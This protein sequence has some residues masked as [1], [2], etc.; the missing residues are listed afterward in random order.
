MTGPLYSDDMDATRIDDAR[1][2]RFD[3]LQADAK[4]ALSYSANTIDAIVERYREAF[5]EAHARYQAVRDEVDALERR[6]RREPIGEDAG[7]ATGSRTPAAEAAEAAEAGADDARTRALRA[8]L[9]LL[10]SDV[11]I[12]QTELARL[13]LAH[14]SLEN[15]WLFLEPGDASLV[16]DGSVEGGPHAVEMRIVEAQEAE[17]SRLAQEIHDGLAQALSNT[18]FQV[19][20]IERV[21]DEDPKL[22]RTELRLMRELL[23]R[24]LGDVRAFISQLR[25]SRLAEHWLD[26]SIVDAADTIAALGGTTAETDLRA[27]DDKLNEA[28]QTVVLR[29]IQ[30]ALQNVRKH[31]RAHQ[32]TIATR[33]LDQTWIAEVRDDGHGFDVGAVAARGRRNFGLQF[34]RERAELIGAVL[35]ISS[36]PEAGTVV[37]LTVPIAEESR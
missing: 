27:P 21:L 36:G 30:E 20:Y 18:I 14:R 11:G 37:R 8:E 9:E 3:E 35:E 6:P 23:R 32:T 33:M 19:Q 25:P 29:V 10:E 28:Q 16:T 13:D 12:H 31:A 24:E 5:R 2:A 17:R 34:M 1:D 22:A 4:A 15:L 26:G 7:D